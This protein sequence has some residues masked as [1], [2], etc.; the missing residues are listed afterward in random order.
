MST[1]DVAGFAQAKRAWLDALLAEGFTREEAIAILT[2][3]Y[4]NIEQNPTPEQTELVTK[5]NALL[6]KELSR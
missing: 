6:N 5:L 2:V 4:V 3:P 1:P